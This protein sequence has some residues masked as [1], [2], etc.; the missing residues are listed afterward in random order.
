MRTR[1]TEVTSSSIR[2][3]R[4][5]VARLSN[6]RSGSSLNMRIQIAAQIENYLLFESIVQQK[7]QGI[8]SVLEEQ[9]A[10][11]ATRHQRQQPL[12]MMPDDDFVDDP[13]RL[14]L[15]KQ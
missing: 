6:Q 4:S 10:T 9:R 2:V 13:F 11:A 12:R 3:I 14:P 8:Q 7:A 15:E 5:P 1:S